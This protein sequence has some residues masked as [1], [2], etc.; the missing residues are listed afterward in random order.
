MKKK[1]IVIIILLASKLP[2]SAQDTTKVEV[3]E[4]SAKTSSL[5]RRERLNY[6]M[7]TT[8]KWTMHDEK[9]MAKI[10]LMSYG[11][12]FYGGEAVLVGYE[13]KLLPSFS[14]GGDIM[15][16]IRLL[17]LRANE[18]A[19]NPIIPSLYTRF[20]YLQNKQLKN[21][22]SGNN[23][24]S[25]YFELRG[26]DLYGNNLSFLGITYISLGLQRRV[27][28]YGYFDAGFGIGLSSLLKIVS[29][30]KPMLPLV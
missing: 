10:A 20:Y 3:F 13:H 27:G 7:W 29:A 17:K 4:E 30:D 8:F 11:N 5:K 25:N 14:L 22:V 6:A 18:G 24:L 1:L 16:G 19:I 9:G 28:R 26:Y 2:L 21:H 23:L 12:Y 15:Y